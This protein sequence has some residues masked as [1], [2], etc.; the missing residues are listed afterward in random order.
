MLSFISIMIVILLCNI[1]RR[2]LC[3][4]REIKLFMIYTKLP[5][6]SVLLALSMNAFM[7]DLF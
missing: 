6:I 4:H 1:F 2:T 7:M 3:I 5:I